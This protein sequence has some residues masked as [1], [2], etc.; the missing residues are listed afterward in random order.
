MPSPGVA[1]TRKQPPSGGDDNELLKRLGRAIRA[2]RVTR[3]L[4]QRELA[5]RVQKSQNYIW[6]LESGK[7]DPGVLFLRK[8][9][10]ALRMSV[11]FF[12]VCIADPRPN[13]PPERQAVF[14]EGQ[15]LMLELL[16][17]LAGQEGEPVGKK[18]AKKRP[19]R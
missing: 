1:T 16:H 3:G 19:N 6:L 10:A 12:F 5:S 9:A 11:D 7:K 15:D 4:T 17:S 14:R 8:L 13:S 18:A 2:V